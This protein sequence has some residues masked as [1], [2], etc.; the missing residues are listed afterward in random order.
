MKVHQSGLTLNGLMFSTILQK[1]PAVFI[2]QPP[3][4]VQ[5]KAVTSE[6]TSTI[7]T[8][9]TL[10]TTVEEAEVSQGSRVKVFIWPISEG[11]VGSDPVPDVNTPE[12]CC[13]AIIQKKKFFS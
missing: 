9:E 10:K 11:G 3:T 1:V 5:T 13:F 6:Q 12:V 2:Q 8:S 4:P 7:A